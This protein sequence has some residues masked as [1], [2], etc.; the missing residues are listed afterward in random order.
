M[1][2]TTIALLGIGFLLVVL[3]LGKPIG[4]SMLVTGYVGIV[5]VLGWDPASH[6]TASTVWAQFSSYN[7]MVVPMFVLMGTLTYRSGITNALYEAA[8]TWVGSFK[9]GMASTTIVASAMFGAICGSLTATTAT[10][11]TIAL[12]EMKK[13]DYEPSFS[14]GAVA[15][16]GVLGVLI[17]PSVLLII[18]AVQTGQRLIDL[19]IAGLVPGIILLILFLL[20]VSV[21][22]YFKPDY[23]PPGP[24]TSWGE[25]FKSLTGLTET[26]ILFV[27]V[28]YGLY[29]GWFT[30]TEAGAAGSA[31]AL[32]ISLVR[33]GMGWTAFNQAVMDALRVSAMVILLLAGAVLFGRFMSITRLPHVL[34]DWALAL[35]VPTW[36]ILLVILLIYLI[37][38]CITDALGFL[39]VSIPIFFPVAEALQF[40]LL[41]FSIL[42][43]VVSTMGAITPP[44]GISVY[45]VAGLDEDIRVEDVFKG[46]LPFF[47][48]FILCAAIIFLF[49]Q[50]ITF[51]HGI[52]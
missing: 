18:I 7:L 3:M 50:T 47:L 41:W 1:S 46:I 43:G 36:G 2:G 29:A 16:G 42:I 45:I 15:V 17:P 40:D 33:G 37:G 32:V 8:Y 38:G 26:I 30:P 25:K 52:A 20:S 6:L 9:G 48:A 13:Y 22:C 23:G 11:G 10:M 21:I 31:G 51:I 28:M 4:I 39:I 44:V 12:P 49:P 27:V 19:F 35:P 24:P 14:G 5:F 34:A